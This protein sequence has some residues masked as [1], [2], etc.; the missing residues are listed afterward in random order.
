MPGNYQETTV[1]GT[2]WI[3][4]YRVEIENQLGGVPSVV[5]REQRAITLA[6]GSVVIVPI[7]PGFVEAEFDAGAQIPLINPWTG[8]PLTNVDGVQQYASHIEAYILLH[9]LYL[10]TAAARDAIV[11]NPP[12]EPDPLYDNPPPEDPP[13]E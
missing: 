10:Q 13:P 11:D 2:T 3:R 12:V 6:D 5:F 8:E 4:S 9:S 1:A 7:N